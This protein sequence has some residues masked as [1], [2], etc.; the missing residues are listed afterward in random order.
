MSNPLRI[1]EEVPAATTI[2]NP[3]IR[4]L[5]RQ[6]GRAYIAGPA[7]EDVRSVCDRLGTDGITTTV[8]YWDVSFESPRAVADSYLRLLKI[9][10]ELRSDC[11]LSIKAPALRFDIGLVKTI[12]DEAACTNIRVHF[13]AM[14]P[15]T[16]D[17]TFSLIRASHKIYPNIG[18]VLPARWGR[19]LRDVDLVVDLGLRVRVVKGQ[20]A[21]FRAD[22]LNPLEGFSRLI[23][24]LAARGAAHVAVAS[25]N[26]AVARDTLHRL[27]TAGTSCELELLYGLPQQNMLKIAREQNTACRIYVPCG[28]P[29]LPYRL[30]EFRRDP[31]VLAWFVRDLI[32]S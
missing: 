29:A 25:H 15:E 10:P 18:C 6:A 21:T 7:V 20:W 30:K 4:F 31:R 22:E 23:D 16:V 8:C 11:Y 24:R 17:R 27:K 9:I 2:R 14:S 26:P 1:V 5:I 3:A 28:H 12:L 32:R 13:D 19:S